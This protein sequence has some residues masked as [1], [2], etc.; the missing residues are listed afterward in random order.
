MCSMFKFNVK[1]NKQSNTHYF[2]RFID[3]KN[4]KKSGFKPKVVQLGD[5]RILRHDFVKV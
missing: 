1:K 3:D 5:S 4:H 2:C